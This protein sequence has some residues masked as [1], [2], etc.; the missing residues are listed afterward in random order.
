MQISTAVLCVW[1]QSILHLPLQTV[2]N[3]SCVT[4]A[5]FWAAGS[6]LQSYFLRGQKLLRPLQA[7]TF[8]LTALSMPAGVKSAVQ[9]PIQSS[10]KLKR[11]H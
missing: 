9:Q 6:I 10:V 2:V 8:W 3:R 5:L 11:D 1:L 4:S 7:N